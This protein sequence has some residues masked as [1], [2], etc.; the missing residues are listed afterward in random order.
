MWV[1][2]ATTGMRRGEVLGLRW[3]DVDLESA[4]I[5]VRQ[6]LVSV[7]SELLFCPPKTARGKRVI[8]LDNR[9]I[10]VIR[11]HMKQVG[12]AESDDLLFTQSDGTPLNPNRVTKTFH[13]LIAAAGLP[14]I[15]L[16][17][18]RHTHATIA[19]QAGVHPKIV[20]ERLG[21]S[22]ISLTLDVYS[23]AIPHMQRDAADRI[24]KLIFG[25]S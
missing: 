8:A 5:A 13:E 20:S 9:T 25:K 21:H 7:G 19:L 18:L 1:L 22:T 4:T 10:Q 14:R 24:G 6:T 3:C 16:H 11:R 17:D 23:H 12:S 2:F 15:R